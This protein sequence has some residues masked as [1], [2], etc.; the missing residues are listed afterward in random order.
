GE[1]VVARNAG[2]AGRHLEVGAVV[3]YLVTGATGLLGGHLAEMLV[4]QG[5]RPRILVRPDESLGGLDLSH[6][7][8]Y[9]GDMSDGASLEAAVDGVDTV[10][11]CAA[12]TGPWGDSAQYELVNVRGLKLL[13]LAAMAAGVRRIVHVSSITVHGNDISGFA[14]ERAPLRAE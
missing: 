14:D 4:A 13:V 2:A 12:R 6:M 1:P 3:T 9:R 10:L 8:V 5:E 11:H 7:D